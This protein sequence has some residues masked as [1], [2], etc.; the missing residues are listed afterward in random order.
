MA[1]FI[2]AL[3]VCYV[4]YVVYHVL[5]TYMSSMLQYMFLLICLVCSSPAS[6]EIMPTLRHCEIV[7]G[8]TE[9]V[10]I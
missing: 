1:V 5:T 7:C 10:V 6:A 3:F 4:Y 2:S 9:E 8:G